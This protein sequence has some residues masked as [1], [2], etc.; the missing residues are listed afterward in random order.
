MKT[1]NASTSDARLQE[2]ATAPIGGLLWKYSL[3][4]VIG[5]VATA[6]YNIIDSI[7][8]GHA[9]D[10]PDVISGIAVT[11]PVMTLSG[12]L[13]ML[14]GAG[15]AARISIVLGQKDHRRAELILGNALV[16]TL[17]IAA[18][19]M[20]TFYIFLDPI[21]R[22]FGASDHSII[23]AREF[24]QWIIPGMVLI[25]LTFGFN[26]LMRATGYPK[27]AMYTNI[28]GAVMNAI[29][30]PLFLFGFGWGIWGAALATDISMAITAVWVLSHFMNKTTP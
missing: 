2:L 12:A 25:N 8:I 17:I 10:N 9:I 23:F 19:Y 3:P 30:A 11:F 13:G 4:A 15:S 18:A 26:N 27:K 14:I 22:I 29:L 16:L 5:I 7:V 1:N 20:T 24:M 6:L 21:L 28:F